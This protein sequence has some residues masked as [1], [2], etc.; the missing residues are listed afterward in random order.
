MCQNI[1]PFARADAQ[2]LVSR[3]E[4]GT[5]FLTWQRFT[6]SFDPADF[7]RLST[8]VT[9]AAQ[10]DCALCSGDYALCPTAAGLQ[11]WVAEVGLALSPAEFERLRD[12]LENAL[13]A[14]Q[15]GSAALTPSASP[16]AR[17]AR[18]EDLN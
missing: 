15:T 13:W 9:C 12:L 2:H 18:K 6:W 3:C 10:A 4:H 17:L 14:L 1:Q 16:L 11:L 7:V 8:F 5:L